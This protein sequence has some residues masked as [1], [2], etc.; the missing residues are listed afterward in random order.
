[1]LFAVAAFGD[2]PSDE[3]SAAANDDSEFA[4]FASFQALSLPSLAPQST[5]A[6]HSLPKTDAN[7]VAFRETSASHQQAL[8]P[9]SLFVSD[10]SSL[11]L[12]SA[13]VSDKYRMIKE[14][15]GDPSLFT[16]GSLPAASE[17]SENS[18]SE[19]SDFQGLSL[20]NVHSGIQSSSDAS[21]RPSLSPGDDEWADFRGTSAVVVSHSGQSVRTF[22]NT[23]PSSLPDLDVD[24]TRVRTKLSTVDDSSNT[25][26][27]FGIQQNNAL[28][29]RPSHAMFSSR[30]LDFTPPELPPE[31]D[32]DD[33]NFHNFDD[34]GQGISSLSTWD[35][36]DEAADRIQSGG[37]FMKSLTTSNSAS[38]FEFT[39]WRQGPKHCLS[40]PGGDN[41]SASSL[42]LQP[43]LDTLNGL[44]DRSPSQ[45]TAE[46][47]SQSES[48][49]E[50]FPPAET[51][52]LPVIGAVRA[53]LDAA[54][55]QSLE[56]KP[57]VVSPEEEPSS[58]IGGDDIALAGCHSA[59]GV[60]SGQ[61]T[62]GMPISNCKP[63]ILR[64]QYYKITK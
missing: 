49:L 42:D 64:F 62:S 10:S 43:T 18:N 31:N 63:V 60:D 55:L 21:F 23:V 57:T 34:G 13:G 35:P 28:Y 22:H 1:L 24:S 48:S 41:Q 33:T 47:D 37:G 58:G 15:I 54:S 44:P 30:A 46:A 14:M 9:S 51:G 26:S 12:S 17:L 45:P 53:D 3:V 2:Q 59:I 6:S 32:D 7:D 40:V 61:E 25:T 4:D 16:S 20:A 50:F 5:I 11:A 52:Q 27:W 39:G 56:L 38:S 36:E 29:G 19:W 8:T